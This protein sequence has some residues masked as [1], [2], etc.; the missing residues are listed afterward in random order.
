MEPLRTN[1]SFIRQF[2][3]ENAGLPQLAN[4]TLVLQASAEGRLEDIEGELSLS[5][6]VG[7][8]VAEG[9]YEQTPNGMNVSASVAS[10]QLQLKRLLQALG[11]DS[12]AQDV[13]FALI[14]D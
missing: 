6:S 12:L 1:L 9:R 2:V 5:S 3:G 14:P 11:Q 13:K 10:K 8:L 7:K 4:D